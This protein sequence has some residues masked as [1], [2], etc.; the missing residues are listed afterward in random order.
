MFKITDEWIAQHA[1]N[2]TVGWTAKQLRSIGVKFPPPA[3]WRR[4]AVGK[5]ITD[6]QRSKFETINKK[7]SRR[8]E[9]AK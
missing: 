1:T 2:G 8:I 3:G 6:E 9:A 7:A 5:T 4:G